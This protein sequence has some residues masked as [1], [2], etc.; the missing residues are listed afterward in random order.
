MSWIVVATPVVSGTVD[1]VVVTVGA[2]GGGAG[3][4][5]GGPASSGSA[6]VSGPI[7]GIMPAN[8]SVARVPTRTRAPAAGWLARR[9]RRGEGVGSRSMPTTSVRSGGGGATAVDR[10]AGSG[11][12]N[13]V[14]AS[15]GPIGRVP[16]RLWSRAIRSSGVS[17]AM[18]RRALEGGGAGGHGGV[19]RH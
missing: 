12:G 17:S 8:P 2:A 13:G 15:T 19:V 5:S 14:G 6:A 11:G 1:E 3:V 7:I 4:G 10:V 16:R 9:G 18:R